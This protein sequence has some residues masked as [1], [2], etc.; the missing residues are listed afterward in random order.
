[1]QST[2]ASWKESTQ[3]MQSSLKF[4]RNK[5]LTLLIL[6]FYLS[7]I[8][9][10][11]MSNSITVKQDLY[12]KTQLLREALKTWYNDS[13]ILKKDQWILIYRSTSQTMIA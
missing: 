5:R 3:V 1:M 9:A 6:V 13:T 4:K 7:L 10:A 11:P 8:L 12:H 2:P